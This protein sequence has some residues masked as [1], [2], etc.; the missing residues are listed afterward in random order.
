MGVPHTGNSSASAEFLATIILE[1]VRSQPDIRPTDIK[2]DI[3]RVYGIEIPYSRALA[4]KEWAFNII[5]GTHEE[6]YAKL[7]KY[8]E[9]LLVA[10]PRS[11]REYERTDTN[12]FRRL[13]L[14]YNASAMGFVSC[15]LLLSLD[16]T[17]IKNKYQGILLTATATDAQGQLFPLAFGIVDIDV[18]DSWLWFLTKL[19]GVFDQ[20]I[21][22]LINVL[23]ALTFLSDRQKGL[24]YAVNELFPLSAH[25]YCLK[26]LEKNLKILYKHKDL[27]PRLW[28][29]AVAKTVPEFEQHM[30]NFRKIDNEA[31]KWLMEHT[32]PRHWVDC[33]FEGHRYGHYTSNI[34]EAINAWLLDAREQPLQPM[35]ETIRDQLMGWF[36]NRREE[37]AKM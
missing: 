17:S 26:H 35:L 31:F 23:N 21:P 10:N 36:D 7:P 16:G 9:Q 5:N 11:F 32:E 28:K 29:A 19:R 27:V 37:G 3:H 4:T 15:K 18:K 25:G 1:K 22:T 13:F 2:K 34:A 6:S 30:E 33:Y 14:G 24:I 8:C 12:Q 20:Y